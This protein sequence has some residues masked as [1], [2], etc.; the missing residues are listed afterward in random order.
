MKTIYG[1]IRFI[2]TMSCLLLI[3]GLTGCS[4]YQ[5]RGVVIEGAV[6]TMTVVDQD[7]PR[8]TQGYGMPMASIEVTL[9]PDRLARKVLQRALSDI[10]GTFAVPVE[11]PGAG[12]LEYDIRVV[13]RRSGYNTAT[14]D[15]R[16]PGP[17]QRLLVTLVGGE[18]NYKPEPPGLMDETLE[19]GEPYMQ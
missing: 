8:L 10:D 18:D 13:V 12:Y 11:E 7:D 3:S 16:L 1:P 14:Q 17:K 15:I 5:M 19:M 2:V 4:S 9:D 6:S